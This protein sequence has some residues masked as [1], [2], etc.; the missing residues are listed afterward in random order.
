MSQRCQV[1]CKNGAA[2]SI[3]G[4]NRRKRVNAVNKSYG[5]DSKFPQQGK[6]RIFLG[7]EDDQS[8]D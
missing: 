7:C 1:P 8:V 6:D 3:V 5:G 4:N 2:R